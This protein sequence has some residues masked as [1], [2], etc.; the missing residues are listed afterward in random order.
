MQ[1]IVTVLATWF[2]LLQL[3]LSG[4]A[5]ASESKGTSE[6]AAKI[7]KDRSL[8][9]AAQA[10]RENPQ[11]APRKVVIALP[12]SLAGSMPDMEAAVR[13]AAA[14]VELVVD[15]SGGWDLDPDLLGGADAIIGFC[16][17][18]VLEAADDELLWLHSYT[19]GVDR[20]SGL[21][22]ELLAGRV[23]SNSKRLSGPTIAEHSI[24]MLLSLARGLPAF[25][26]AQIAGQWDRTIAGQDRFGELNGKT[27]L[28]VGL[29]GI[30]TEVARRAHGL[31][32]RVMATRNSSRTGPD[33][34]DYVGLA[35][36]L[37]KLAAQ[38]DVIVN[39]L[40]LT[41]E[42]EGLF[43]EGFF[44]QTKAGAIFISVPSRVKGLELS[45]QMMW[46]C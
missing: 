19:V 28:V 9:E 16:S 23:F 15:R 1:L 44:A 46:R 29:G 25:Q 39:A 21:D 42:T 14:G 30:G 6:A 11:W 18:A 35:D 41:E 17:K 45:E 5:A 20:C 4:P 32:M 8:Q 24:A 27:L 10:I 26:R 13:A 37:G 3:T 34:V 7:I 12:P 31:G 2:M 36:E 43:D 38:A 33:F 22:E 40:P